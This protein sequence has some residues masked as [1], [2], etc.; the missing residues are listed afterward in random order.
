M[1]TLPIGYADG[2]PRAFSSKETVQRG[3]EKAPIIGSICMD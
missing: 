1:A 3:G 2:L